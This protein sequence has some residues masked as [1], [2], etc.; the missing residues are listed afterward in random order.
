MKIKN[1]NPRT[2]TRAEIIHDNSVGFYLY[3]YDSLGRCFADHLQDSLQAAQEQ[4]EED[5]GMAT[6][7]WQEA[8]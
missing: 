2:N 8:T 7:S 1:F 4:A 6:D 3:L 5:Y